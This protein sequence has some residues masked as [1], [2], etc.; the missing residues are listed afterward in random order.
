MLAVRRSQVESNKSKT[1]KGAKVSVEPVQA[2]LSL[3]VYALESKTLETLAKVLVSL[4]DFADL[5]YPPVHVPPW[6]PMHARAS[7]AE[8]AAASDVTKNAVCGQ[9]LN[10]APLF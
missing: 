9:L 6:Q 4:L 5:N 2:R 10:C 8:A 1:H 7:R 3:K